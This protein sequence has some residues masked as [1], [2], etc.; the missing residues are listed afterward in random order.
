M[1]MPRLLAATL[2]TATLALGTGF[3]VGEHREHGGQADGFHDGV[4]VGD[5]RELMR[6]SP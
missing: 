5:A 2:L 6:P 4:S 1:P 3:A